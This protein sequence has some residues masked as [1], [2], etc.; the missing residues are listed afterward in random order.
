MEQLKEHRSA[1]PI[2]F[3]QRAADFRNIASMNLRVFILKSAGGEH[4]ALPIGN[5]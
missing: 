2:R 4:I 1:H 3:N 5:T